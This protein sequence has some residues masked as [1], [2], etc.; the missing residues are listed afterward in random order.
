MDHFEFRKPRMPQIPEWACTAWWYLKTACTRPWRLLNISCVVPCTNLE[1]WLH[2][3]NSAYCYGWWLE[4]HPESADRWRLKAGNLTLTWN[5]A[6]AEIASQPEDAEEM[7]EAEE[8]AV[9]EPDGDLQ[10]QRYRQV[11]DQAC[12]DRQSP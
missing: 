2:W 12:A 3:G 8:T 10:G 9:Q 5:F 11:H 7:E 4:E 1:I 6:A